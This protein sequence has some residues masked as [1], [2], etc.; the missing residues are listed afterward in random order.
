M[1]LW[2]HYVS[3]ITKN[4][5]NEGGRVI[6]YFCVELNQIEKTGLQNLIRMNA[7]LINFEIKRIIFI[8]KNIH[9]LN[10]FAFDFAI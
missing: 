4:R 9:Y 1:A 7:K 6:K 3:V 2:R 10:T 8:A 5:D